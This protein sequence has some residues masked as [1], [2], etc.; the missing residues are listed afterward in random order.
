VIL[1]CLIG[2]LKGVIRTIWFLLA[3]KPVRKER[4]KAEKA[5]RRAR[6]KAPKRVKKA[7]RA[8]RRTRRRWF[9]HSRMGGW[10]TGMM[11]VLK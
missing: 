11:S 6:A 9:A 5:V 7:R 1:G 4:R 3:P 10:V 8:A 2:I